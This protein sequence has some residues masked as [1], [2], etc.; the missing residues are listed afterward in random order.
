MQSNVDTSQGLAI[1]DNWLPRSFHV[2]EGRRSGRLDEIRMTPQD[3][4]RT[5]RTLWEL[6]SHP[7]DSCRYVVGKT[8]YSTSRRS[9]EQALFDDLFPVL[10]GD[11]RHLRNA[12]GYIDPER[13]RGLE[14]ELT[15]VHQFDE[16]Y[17]QPYCRLVAI[18]PKSPAPHAS[19]YSWTSKPPLGSAA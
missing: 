15:I 3:N 6:E 12:H 5:I 17:E 4:G 10:G 18:R 9:A 1:P 8:Y 7:G 11:L 13:L 14:A 19:N 2:P 16:K